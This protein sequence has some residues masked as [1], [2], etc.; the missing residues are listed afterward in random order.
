MR[1]FT[2]LTPVGAIVC[3]LLLYAAPQRAATAK[4]ALSTQAP[5]SIR[6][7]NAYNANGS[8]SNSSCIRRGSRLISGAMTPKQ[9]KSLKQIVPCKTA[10]RQK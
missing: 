9:Q 5:P 1:K 7:E 10:N 8:N 2:V 6:A 3:L 4:M